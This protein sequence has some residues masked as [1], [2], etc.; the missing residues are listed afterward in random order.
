[1]PR[2][3][4]L[5]PGRFIL[6]TLLQSLLVEACEGIYRSAMVQDFLPPDKWYIESLHLNINTGNGWLEVARNTF[7]YLL[8]PDGTVRI[9]LQVLF[10][11]CWPAIRD[12]RYAT[13]V[14]IHVLRMQTPPLSASISLVYMAW[15]D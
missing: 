6:V 9:V 12:M 8:R 14:I 4:Y 10:L 7:Q 15:C 11:Q 3:S 2:R 1:M 13:F 5:H